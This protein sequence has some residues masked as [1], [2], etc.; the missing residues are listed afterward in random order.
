MR[1]LVLALAILL[2]LPPCIGQAQPAPQTAPPPAAIVATPSPAE[3][4]FLKAVE[5]ARSAY[6]TGINDMVRGVA[7][8]RRAEA[9][10]RAVPRGRVE[11]WEGKLILL[12]SSPGG[13]GIVV[14]E[15]ASKVTLAS[16][17]TDAGDERD[18]TLIDM[19]SPLFASAAALA[20]GDRVQFSGTLIPG[21]D[22]CFKEAGHDLRTAMTEPEF[23]LRLEAIKKL[24]PPP[25]NAVLNGQMA[26]M[27]IAQSSDYVRDSVD[28]IAGAVTCGAEQRRV[29]ATIIRILIRAAAGQT[30]EQRD[31]LIGLMFSPPSQLSQ[32]K[33]KCD[34][35]LAAFARLEAESS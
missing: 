11:N 3:D 19:R 17:R 5:D 28:V 1:P 25:A 34:A 8:P 13:R 32:Q 21:T 33:D 24:V 26:P 16:N 22:D 31:A 7:R 27:S 23:V 18:K 12:G 14:I 6:S 20:V 35:K 29:F 30:V 9:L 4:A 10:C 15:L 2:V